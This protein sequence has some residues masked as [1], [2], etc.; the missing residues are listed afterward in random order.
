MPLQELRRGTHLGRVHARAREEPGEPRDGGDLVPE[1]IAL[2]EGAARVVAN[3]SLDT[4][5]IQER[6]ITRV[7]EPFCPCETLQH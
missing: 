5:N 7:L 3:Y 2:V 4:K 6:C 1:T